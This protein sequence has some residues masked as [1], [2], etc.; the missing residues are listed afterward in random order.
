MLIILAFPI[1][2]Q[3][4]R[5]WNL[6]VGALPFLAQLLG[7]LLGAAG[8]V[9]NQKLYVRAFKANGNRAVPEARLPPMMVG[10]VVFAA[11][12][13][14]FGWTADKTIHWIAPCI[15]AVCMGFG[16]FT[17]FQ[18]CLNY[19]ID[20]FQAYA[21]S[22]VAVN[23]FLRSVFASGFTMAV[24]PMFHNMGIHWACSL[25]GFL[26]VAL[27]PIPY[28]FRIYGKSIRARGEW[29]RGSV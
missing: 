17:I 14:I 29:S 22:A 7:I 2:F 13:F 15:G 8:N 10:S 21:A 16:F 5:G 27:I 1:V 18:A 19:L 24:D 11:G 9:Y 25:L 26:A 4:E 3:E 6:V 23:T 20:T 28:L 12:L